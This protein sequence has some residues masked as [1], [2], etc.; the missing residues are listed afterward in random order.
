MD[1]ANRTKDTVKQR[2]AEK[3]ALPA[4]VALH[5]PEPAVCINDCSDLRSKR[6]YKRKTSNELQFT[7]LMLWIR[8]TLTGTSYCVRRFKPAILVCFTN[9]VP[10]KKKKHPR[11]DIIRDRQNVLFFLNSNRTYIKLAA[12]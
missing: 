1:A 7:R 8:G 10:I 12:V 2:H 11:H 5:E 3:F 6:H 9:G 4:T